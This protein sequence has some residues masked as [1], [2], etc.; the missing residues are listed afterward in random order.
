MKRL[1]GL[2]GLRRKN[3]VKGTIAC[4]LKITFVVADQG[5]VFWGGYKGNHSMFYLLHISFLN[6]KVK[7]RVFSSV[8][9]FPSKPVLLTICPCFS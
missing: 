9:Y 3:I 6:E 1:L 7:K 5:C 4:F 8:V 2:E